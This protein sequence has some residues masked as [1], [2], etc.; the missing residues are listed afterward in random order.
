MGGNHIRNK[1]VAGVIERGQVR[2]DQRI[3]LPRG[4]LREQAGPGDGG[5]VHQDVDGTEI[6]A[7]RFHIVQI[8]DIAEGRNTKKIPRLC[9]KAGGLFQGG[10]IRAAVQYDFAVVSGSG[11]RQRQRPA[12]APGGAGDQK[13]MHINSRRP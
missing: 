4:H 12:D 1:G 9:H 6:P 3:P 5:V 7:E 8:S 10:G 2:A 11:A 13:S